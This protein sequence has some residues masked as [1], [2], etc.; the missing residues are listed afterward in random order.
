MRLITNFWSDLAKFGG[1]IHA[2]VLYTYD[3]RT[4]VLDRVYEPTD[5]D[6]YDYLPFYVTHCK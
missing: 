4:R 6:S 2:Y 3:I 5:Y 1:K